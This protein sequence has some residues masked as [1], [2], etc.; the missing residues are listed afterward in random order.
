MRL[1]TT[2]GAVLMIDDLFR[3]GFSAVFVGTG[4]EK[5]RRLGMPGECFG[6]VHFAL[7][8]L[9]N[10][11]AHHLGDDV[12]VIGV[13]NAAMDVARTALH[14]GAKRVTTSPRAP[15]WPRAAMRFPARSSTA[16]KS[17]QV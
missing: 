12:A 17:K 2:I 6:N 8:Y 7:N 16:R 11:A 3:D 9:A 10:P 14:N 5:P 15:A 13:G 1:N 4:A